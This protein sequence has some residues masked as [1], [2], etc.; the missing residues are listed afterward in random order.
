MQEGNKNSPVCVDCHGSHEI[1]SSK[2][3]IESES[4]LKCHLDEK[5]F[6][7]SDRGPAK[8]VSQYKTSIHSIPRENGNPAAG[9]TDCHGNHMI[10]KTTEPGTSTV[11]AKLIETCK[12]CHNNVVT[13]YETSAHGKA[14]LKGNE[15]SPSCAVCHG[16]HSIKSV[17]MSDEFSK[18][19]QTE[20]CLNC[21][22][23]GKYKE[24]TDLKSHPEDY[25]QSAHY[26]A[27]K[28]GN[29][30]AATC[31]DC[32]GAH[33]MQDA[34][35]TTSNI[36]R[37]N[38]ANSCGRAGC[39]TKQLEEFNGSIHQV[40]LVSKQNSDAPSCVTC[41][42]NHQVMKKEEA[43]NKISSS[44]GIVQLCSD[45]HSS[46]KLIENNNLP[47][48]VTQSYNESF[49]GLAIRG[50]S[51]VAAN[52]ESCHGNHNIRPSDDPLSSINKKKL[53]ETCGKCHPG[54][55]D[56]FFDTPI[57]AFEDRS[58]SPSLFW[59][60]RIYITLIVL[61]IGGMVLH[62]ILDLRKKIKHKKRLKK[63]K[64]SKSII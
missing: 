58:V 51:K 39:H 23:D 42:G 19:N 38:V 33:E 44:K 21:H 4:C 25:K 48:G 1:I 15:N 17:K 50:G 27:L 47:F 59:I 52:C 32:H 43:N 49:H 57:H 11:K 55:S 60:S 54:A 14:F 35:D 6:P 18:I 63:H 22:Q 64:D 16:E 24:L 20:L 5:L 53:P 8:F 56:A 62:N 10:E 40:S 13:N 31:S 3:S 37:K 12:K 46:V 2:L 30:K 9:C 36:N 34:K 45:C 26:L 7:G 28:N 29:T 41:H 61:V